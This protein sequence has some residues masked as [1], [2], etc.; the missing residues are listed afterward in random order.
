MC[1]E[2]VFEEG[3]AEPLF[4]VV[5]KWRVAAAQVHRFVQLAKEFKLE[6]ITHNL[7]LVINHIK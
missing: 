7:L 6:V 1:A 5:V 4:A 3:F 2:N